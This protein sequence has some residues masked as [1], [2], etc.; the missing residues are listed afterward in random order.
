MSKKKTLGCGSFI[1]L[2]VLIFMV[3][4]VVSSPET[5]SPTEHDARPAPPAPATASSANNAVPT[6]NAEETPITIED[7]PPTP[8]DWAKLSADRSKWPATVALTVAQS[9]PIFVQ[10]EQVGD[11]RL[12]VGSEVRLV[13]VSPDGFVDVLSAQRSLRLAADETDLF[14]TLAAARIHAEAMAEQARKDA[15]AQ[16]ETEQAVLAAL[17]GPRPSQGFRVPYVAIDRHLKTSLHD[18]RSLQYVQNSTARVIDRNGDVAWEVWVSYRAK[19]RLG[20][21][22]LNSGTARI[23][24]DRVVSWIEDK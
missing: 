17:I 4:A 14:A 7:A 2:G 19:N 20:A 9:I 1:G 6:P 16:A 5:P 11:Q 3:W 18:P 21:M 12:P 23:K 15:I 8:P 13:H 24:H 22:V 10:G